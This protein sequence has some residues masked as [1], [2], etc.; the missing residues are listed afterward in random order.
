[1]LRH[2]DIPPQMQDSP[3][4]VIPWE[5]RSFITH[6]A[7]LEGGGVAVDERAIVVSRVNE[8]NEAAMLTLL[9]ERGLT[10]VMVPASV[11]KTPL[12]KT[13]LFSTQTV[14][15]AMDRVVEDMAL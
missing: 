14:E 13:P 15:W 10:P 12:G 6:V 11:H 1:M 9:Q 4:D 7:Y 2:Y 3:S 8:S 5:T